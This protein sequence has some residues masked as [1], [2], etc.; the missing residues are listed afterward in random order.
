MPAA[1]INLNPTELR[2]RNR[3]HFA[4]GS[5]PFIQ[6]I[7]LFVEE[8]CFGLFLNKQEYTHVY[9]RIVQTSRQLYYNYP[10]LPD[11]ITGK[12]Y[13]KNPGSPGFI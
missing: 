10:S 12:K 6:C 1:A 9:S 3:F 5:N 2:S 8:K 11:L 4:I 13:D 7:F